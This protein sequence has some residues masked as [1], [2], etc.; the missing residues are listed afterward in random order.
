MRELALSPASG[1]GWLRLAILE[2]APG[3]AGTDA[4]DAALRRSYAVAPFDARLLVPR[5]R[6]AFDH[7]GALDQDQRTSTLRHIELAWPIDFQRARVVAALG[8]VGNPDGHGALR[9]KIFALRIG[10]RIAEKE[11]ESQRKIEAARPEAQ[12]PGYGE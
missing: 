3:G 9:M 1:A 4:A 10:Q 5:T 8:Q 11:A 7:W 2:A 6:F 12:T